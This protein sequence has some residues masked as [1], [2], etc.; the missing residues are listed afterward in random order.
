MASFWLRNLFYLVEE[1]KP[2]HSYPS[3]LG[4]LEGKLILSPS[5]FIAYREQLNS[6]SQVD[7]T[8]AGSE[9]WKEGTCFSARV[10]L[11]AWS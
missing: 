2:P 9:K 8:L 11:S 6:L 5:S 3:N 1:N 7:I 10:R 4:R